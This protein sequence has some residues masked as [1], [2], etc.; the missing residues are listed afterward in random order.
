LSEVYQLWEDQNDTAAFVHDW[1]ST[2][3]TGNL[4]RGLVVPA[5]LT[6]SIER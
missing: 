4:C 5:P 3:R 6:R 2:K 1:C